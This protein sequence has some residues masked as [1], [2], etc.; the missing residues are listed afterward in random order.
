M[1]PCLQPDADQSHDQNQEKHSNTKYFR[2]RIR[3]LTFTIFCR[4]MANYQILKPYLLKVEET[5][6]MVIG[7]TLIAIRVKLTV[8]IESLFLKL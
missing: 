5:Q 6:E 8:H 2:D 7:D 3:N 4:I 1:F